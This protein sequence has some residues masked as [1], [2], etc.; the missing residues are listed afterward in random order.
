MNP[1]PPVSGMVDSRKV[2]RVVVDTNLV[3]SALVFGGGTPANLRRAWQDGSCLPLV[4][5]STAAE[6]LRVLAYPKFGLD[7]QQREQLLGDYLPYCSSVRVPTAIAGLPGCRDPYDLPFLA[8]A[9]A[10]RADYLITGDRDLLDL[11]PGLPY[12]I[13]T[14][15]DFLVQLS[16]STTGSSPEGPQG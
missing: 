12:S 14:A 7:T 5:K 10:G 3:L 2:P 8:L 11:S 4:S 1:T 13:V 6:L 9:D 15:G 16:G